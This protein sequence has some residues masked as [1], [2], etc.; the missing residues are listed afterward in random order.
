MGVELPYE[1]DITLPHA[2][3][4]QILDEL[5]FENF[6]LL[7]TGSRYDGYHM[8]CFTWYSAESFA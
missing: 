2:L 7:S 3:N 8:G 5:I 1:M 6:Q 4:A